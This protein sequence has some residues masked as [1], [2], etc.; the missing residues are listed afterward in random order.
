MTAADCDSC[1]EIAVELAL[2]I[3]VGDERAV[4]LE[5]LTDCPACRRELS[6]LTAALDALMSIAPSEDPPTGFEDRVLK[7]FA[8]TTDTVASDAVNG[9]VVSEEGVP[10]TGLAGTPQDRTTSLLVPLL[11]NRRARVLSGAV[12][13]LLVIAGILGVVALVGHDGARPASNEIAQTSANRLEGVLRTPDGADIGRVTLDTTTGS[14]GSQGSDAELVV[15]LDSAVPAGSYRVE[16][17]YES[18]HPYTAGV[19]HSSPDGLDEWRGTIT[20]PTYDLRRVRLV[21]T[22]GGP[23]LEASMAS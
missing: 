4:A 2:G 1:R 15:S 22:T 20:V 7:T 10:D 11:G 18:G 8:R 3:A 12:A 14:S 6:G 5:H 21:S 9:E 19:L 17:D 16:C 13:T 23:N